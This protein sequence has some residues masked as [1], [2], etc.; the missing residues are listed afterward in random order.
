[1]TLGGAAQLAAAYCL[2]EWTMD[3]T[4]CS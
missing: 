3:S 2:N 4:A 1:M